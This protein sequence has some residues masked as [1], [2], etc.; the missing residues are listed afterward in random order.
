M[1]RRHQYGVRMGLRFSYHKAMN[2]FESKVLNFIQRNNLAVPGDRIV[3]GFSGGADSTALLTALW[4][5]RDILKISIVA[6]HVEHGIREDSM[7]D[8]EFAENFCLKRN[9]EFVLVRENVPEIARQ[10]H[11][12]EEE[13]GREVR[14]ETFERIRKE[15]FGTRIAVAHHENDVAET[16]LFNLVRGT[17]LRGGA[18]IRPLR[19]NVIRPLLCVNRQEIEGYLEGK[20]LTYCTDSTNLE[21][22]HHRNIIRNKVIPLLE[23]ELNPRATEHLARA[24]AD[25]RIADEFIREMTDRTFEQLVKDENGSLTFGAG[26]IM[27]QPELIRRNLVL[28]CIG[29]MCGSVKDI[30]FAHI[31]AV[32]GLAGSDAGCKSVDLP[33][34]LAALRAYDRIRI[35]NKE[36]E[37]EFV[38]EVI[39]LPED[40]L[41]TEI[42]I[43]VLGKAVIRVFPYDEHENIPTD[44]YTKWFDYDRIQSAVFRTRQPS[45]VICIELG[46]EK[47][48]KMLSKYMTDEKIPAFDR[49]RMYI[50]ADD[51]QVIW[52]PGYR[53]SAAYKVSNSTRNVLAISIKDG[54]N[55]NG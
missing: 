53:I 7:K 36:N 18:S 26:E 16:L 9:I 54:G 47:R 6:V 1:Q 25:F 8:A 34:N 44:T 50:L 14:Y 20:G 38:P 55:V 13:A 17:S 28:K 5:L 33:Y 4:G 43:P 27:E 31:N 22:I 3:V 24:A 35:I 32:L 41:E 46:G 29:Q 49:D 21:N 10:R 37:K 42:E 52:I 12:S 40:I 2:G 39:P 45:D 11:L 23:K 48:S 15:K 19:G 51:E 30:S